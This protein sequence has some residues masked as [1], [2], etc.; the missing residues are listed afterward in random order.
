VVSYLHHFCPEISRL[1]HL[2]AEEFVN[3]LFSLPPEIE[4]LVEGVHS[5]TQTTDS[6]HFSEEFLRR[7]KLAEK[8]VV[9]NNSRSPATADSGAAGG[10]SEVAKK[11][12]A[13]PQQNRDEVGGG[14][15][16]VVA[17]KKKGGKR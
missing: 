3:T 2:I 9:A 5:A 4:I 16:K 8:G 14:N 7:R 13:P 12:N 11:G 6:R 1:T 17:P 10:W 15:F